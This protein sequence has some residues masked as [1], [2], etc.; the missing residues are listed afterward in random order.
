[1]S[2]GTL[3]RGSAAMVFLAVAAGCSS[4]TKQVAVATSASPA[5]GATASTTTATTAAAGASTTAAAAST[6]KGSSAGVYTVPGTKL[7][8]MFPAS[9]KVTDT[10]L[11]LPDGT[12]IPTHQAAYDAPDGALFE[13]ISYQLPAA[14]LSGDPK[15]I[16]ADSEAGAVLQT[17]GTVIT[18]SAIDVAGNPGRDFTESVTSGNAKGKLRGRIVLTDGK[19]QTQLLYIAAEVTFDDAAAEAFM[20]STSVGG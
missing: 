1:M 10:P 6:T 8:V 2:T 16:V 7:S 3:A 13:I 18:D 19:V 20:T 9:P 14:R 17:K 11:A 4:S 5:T 12:S 15:Q